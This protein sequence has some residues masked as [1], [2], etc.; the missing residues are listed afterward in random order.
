MERNKITF[1]VTLEQRKQIEDRI[2]S[3]YPALKNVSE[4]VRAALDDFLKDNTEKKVS[5]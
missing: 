5:M 3:E 4:L 1:E 2:K